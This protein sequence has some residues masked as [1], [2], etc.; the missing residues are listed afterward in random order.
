MQINPDFLDLDEAEY[1]PYVKQRA[2]PRPTGRTRHKSHKIMKAEAAERVR[3]LPLGKALE[4]KPGKAQVFSQLAEQ[5]TSRLGFTPT[6]GS[7]SSPHNHMSNH[8]REWIQNYLGAFYEDNLI[9]DV[10]RRVK[11]GKEATVYCCR[12]NPSTGFELVAGKVYHERMFRSLKNDSIYR[13]G[14]AVLDDQ[15]KGVRGRREMLAM[16]K[17]T[18]LG[19]NL[20]HVSWLTGEFQAM[21][22][23]Y[24]A[25]ADI[26]R[27]IVQSD[28]AILMEYVGEERWAA[29]ALHEIKLA[30]AEARP[31]FDRLLRNIELML[32]LDLVH[33]D[34]SAHNIL[35]WE[36][37]VKI[38]DF[39]QAVNP[40][41]NPAAYAFLLRD[42]ER[43]CQYFA[44][45]G[46]QSNPVQ[47]TQDIWA[48][49]IPT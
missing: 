43:V 34:L 20:R 13:E 47:L 18:K 42:V 25:G 32:S 37:E 41:S 14:R 2:R 15:G 9:T 49:C 6:F 22:R 12:A 28:N 33:G 4:P 7:L 48:R 44:R 26:P 8:E 21:Q 24:E 29:P 36:G 39:P 45:L 23:L 35:Y 19:Q 38:I 11:G 27:P 5:D 16:Q 40:Y 17:K 1:D 46:I 10:L 31:L 30:P 3:G